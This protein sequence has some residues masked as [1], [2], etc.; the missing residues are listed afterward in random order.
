ME[1]GGPRRVLFLLNERTGLPN[2]SV[3]RGRS[4]WS[5]PRETERLRGQR[6]MR[7]GAS[8]CPVLSVDYYALR[9]RSLSRE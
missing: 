4:N 1:G 7:E 3:E 9:N 6:G 8:A 5:R 2:R